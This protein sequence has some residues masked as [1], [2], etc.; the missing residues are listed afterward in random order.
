MAILNQ[1]HLTTSCKKPKTD[2]NAKDI[3]YTGPHPS[4]YKGGQVYQDQ[5][6]SRNN[7]NRIS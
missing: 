1:N 3:L 6:K 4:N 2:T 7:R 5:R